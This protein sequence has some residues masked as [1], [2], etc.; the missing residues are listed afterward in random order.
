MEKKMGRPLKG[1]T[2]LKH[3][4]KVRF[5]DELFSKLNEYCNRNGKERAEIIRIATEKYLQQEDG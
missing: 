4:V 5:D 3:D 2:S 1:K